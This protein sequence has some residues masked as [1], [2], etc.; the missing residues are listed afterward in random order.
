MPNDTPV[1]SIGQ[2]AERASLRPS[3]IHFYEKMGLLRPAKR[4]P[5]G[6]RLY[7][8]TDIRRL[9][10]IVLLRELGCTLSDIRQVAELNDGGRDMFSPQAFQAFQAVLRRKRMA[11][12]RLEQA[13]AAGGTPGR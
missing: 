13:L 9:E 1:F 5:S 4:S 8:A 2:L 12:C 3:A 7:E 10:L 11:L 6:H